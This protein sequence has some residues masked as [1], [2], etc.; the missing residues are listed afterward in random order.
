MR[1]SAPTLQ[2]R[3]YSFLD[4][5]DGAGLA[6]RAFNALLVLLIL[7][8]VIV[9]VL[10]T[11]P[12][13]ARDHGRTIRLFELLSVAVFGLEYLA[14]LYVVPLRPGF[15][16]GWR[17]YVRY[18]LSPLPL[19]DLLVIVSLLVPATA[20]LASLRGLRLLKLLSLLKLG[21]YSNSLLLIGRVIRQRAGELLSTVLIVLVLVFIAASLLY[22]V[23]SS[24]GTKGFESIP[25]ALWWAVVTLTTTGYGDVYPATPLGKIT[26]GTI[27][28]FGVGMVALP[29]GMI[30]SGFA[31]EMARLRQTPAP[32]TGANAA[33]CPHCG[34]ELP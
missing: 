17:G 31:E 30:A 26:A 4:P 19:L 28:L 34:G 5:S 14:R 11:V 16:D 15:G 2:D 1:P 6:E 22:Q 12:E 20:A 23:E 3:L 13:V 29:A 18:I 32:A 8:N 33:R 24:A 9:T 25:H 10:A 7:L 21:Q 27:M